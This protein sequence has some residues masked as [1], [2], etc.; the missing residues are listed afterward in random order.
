MFPAVASFSTVVAWRSRKVASEGGI[1]AT[2][3]T[4]NIIESYLSCKYKGHLKLTGE[5]GTISDYEAMTTAATTSSREEALTRLA[6]RF[7][8][9]ATGQGGWSPPPP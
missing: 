5:N 7:G 2:K 6:A 9:G 1:M 8:E 4:R 3:I